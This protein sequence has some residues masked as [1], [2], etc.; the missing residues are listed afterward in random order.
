M[1][2]DDQCDVKNVEE[3]ADWL[4]D[5]FDVTF[6]LDW[7]AP[8]STPGNF[9]SYQFL[10]EPIQKLVLMDFHCRYVISFYVWSF[11]VQPVTI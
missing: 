8:W 2:I 5:P 4:E 11:K 6:D 1:I 9:D 10:I 3:P 7:V